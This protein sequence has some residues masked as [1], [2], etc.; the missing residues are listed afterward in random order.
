MR[1]VLREN[2]IF[3][4]L[5]IFFPTFIFLID[6]QIK[7]DCK[8]YAIEMGCADRNDVTNDVVAFFCTNAV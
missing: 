8:V 3:L 1:F 4:F 7:F 6:T 5:Y 2:I